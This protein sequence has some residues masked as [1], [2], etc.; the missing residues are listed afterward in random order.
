MATSLK[1]VLALGA[2]ILCAPLALPQDRASTPRSVRVFDVRD[3]VELGPSAS[4]PS[5]VGAGER[6]G[7][8]LTPANEEAPHALSILVGFLDELADPP[9]DNP[10]EG[11]FVDWIEGG[12]LMVLGDAAR[13][14]W[15]QGVLDGIRTSEVMIHVRV[16]LAT[17]PAGKLD[18]VDVPSNGE[19]SVMLAHEAEALLATARREGAELVTS[20]ALMALPLQRA[21]VTITRQLLFVTDWELRTVEPDGR[22]VADPIIETVSDGVT[23]DVMGAP[24]GNGLFALDLRLTVAALEEPVPS[25]QRVL[26]PGLPPVEV[27]LPLLRKTEVHTRVALVPGSVAVFTARGPEA[28]QDL[29][30]LVELGDQPER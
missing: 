4:Q 8:E 16:R 7:L 19:P 17:L 13:H 30:L 20:P 14:A 21:M 18:L 29:L 26:A 6:R 28:L 10:P 24:F 5:A 23:L 12:H 2:L 3:L 27:S 11:E 15:V 1:P 22:K 9:L 25:E